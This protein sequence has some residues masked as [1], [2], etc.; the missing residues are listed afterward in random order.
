MTPEFVLIG[1]AL[2][3]I[4]FVV[5]RMTA[6][7][8]RTTV[9]YEPPR[10]RP[11]AKPPSADAGIEA[12]LRAGNKIEAIRRYRQLNGTS[13]KEAKDAVEALEARLRR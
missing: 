10:S 2:L 12:S 13:L 3:I 7:R 4:G 8:Q 1:A 6:P 5:G 11:A 9:T